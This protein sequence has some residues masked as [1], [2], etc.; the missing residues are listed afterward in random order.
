MFTVNA[1][2]DCDFMA[3]TRNSKHVGEQVKKKV[4]V[5]DY[6]YLLFRSVAEPLDKFQT[7]LDDV[8]GGFAGFM[9]L[10]SGL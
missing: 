9:P 6:H 4:I 5:R 7:A 1:T 10:V 2:I 3:G 8:P